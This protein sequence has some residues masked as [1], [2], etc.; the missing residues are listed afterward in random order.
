[1]A[2]ESISGPMEAS[3]EETGSTTKSMGTVSISGTMAGRTRVTGKTTT[4]MVRECTN[5]LTKE[6]TMESTSMTK[7]MDLELTLIQMDVVTPDFGQTVSNM[8]K[9]LSLR[10]TVKRKEVSGRT[11]K[12]RDGWMRMKQ[13]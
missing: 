1:M 6:S 7:N 3:T 10:L 8:E 9:A 2:M 13:G 12:E 4:C 11:V 5:G